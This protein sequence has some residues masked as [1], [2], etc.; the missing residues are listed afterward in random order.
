[1]PVQHHFLIISCSYA[2]NLAVAPAPTRFAI[3]N[4]AK[5][6]PAQAEFSKTESGNALLLTALFLITLE[7][8][9]SIIIASVNCLIEKISNIL[10]FSLA[11]DQKN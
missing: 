10:M 5:S 7:F 9:L 6:N 3:I 8:W 2:L 4:P 1:M 11:A